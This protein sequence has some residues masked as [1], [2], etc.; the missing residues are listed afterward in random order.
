[1]S[2]PANLAEKRFPCGQ[3]G[4]QLAFEPGADSLKCGYCGFLNPIPKDEGTVEELDFHHWLAIAREDTQAEEK[5]VVKCNGCAAEFSASGAA[6][7]DSCPFC[8]SNVI[9]PVP[10]EVRVRPRS[11]LPF[12]LNDKQAREAFQR[13]IK[14]RWLAPNALKHFARDLGRLQGMYVPFWTYDCHALTQYA[15]MRGIYRYR[16]ET[17]EDSEGRTQTRQVRET[18]WYPCSGEVENRFD[19][20]LVPAST[21]LPEHHMRAMQR[22][23]LH[24]LTPYQDAFLSGFR[25][26]RYRIG[27]EQGFETAREI[28]EPTIY[29]T[30]RSDIGGDE[31]RVRSKETHY[32]EITFK[33]ILLPIWLGAYKFKEKTYSFSVNARTGEVVGDAPISFWK[34]LGLVLLA[35]VVIGLLIL[36]SQRS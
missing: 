31:Q 1:M 17:Y 16:T 6:M 23:D 14:S 20:V 12:R 13:W 15:G 24:E 8:G 30:I 27:L 4:A 34:V 18:D 2:V 7:S 29:S 11:L 3:C 26:E 32:D 22:W 33:H 28:M 10:Q 5:Q 36:F 9:V 25:T 35:L 19:D 21:S